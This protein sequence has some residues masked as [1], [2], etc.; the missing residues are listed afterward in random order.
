MLH[1]ALL[2]CLLCAALAQLGACARGA[3]TTAPGDGSVDTNTTE[4][5]WRPHIGQ[6]RGPG[7]KP[8]DAAVHTP[9]EGGAG[10]KKDKGPGPAAVDKDGDGHCSKGT[11]DP[12]GK[13]KSFNDCDDKDASRH[14]GAL[15]TCK[16]MGVDNDCDGDAKE[17]DLNKDGK[18]DLGMACQTSKPGVCSAGQKRC[19]KGKLVCQSNI[20]PGQKKETCNGQDDDCDGTAD[21]GNLCG[22]G[23]SCQGKKGCRCATSPACVG[24]EQCCG[25]SCQ[26]IQKDPSHCGGCGVAC[27]AGES[28][29]GGAC[30][31]G[32]TVGKVGGGKACTGGTCSGGACLACNPGSNL[33][34][35][36]AASSSGGG[37]GV[38]GP[39]AMRNNL[40]QAQCDFHWVSA[41]SA[42]GGKWV[43][44]SWSSPVL[45][46]RVWFD[47]S[48]LSGSC[49]LSSG[50]TLYGGKVQY[51][52][53]GG[54]KS[55]AVVSGKT[56]D[57]S[58]SF[59]QVST[60]KLR[61]HDLHAPNTIGQ[62]SNPII[63]EWRVYCK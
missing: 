46:G 40:L 2:L 43:Q 26:D 37:F 50:R 14:P 18:S 54:W 36:A 61:F 51:W 35:A 27:G 45:V 41:G 56:S 1:R 58:V 12:K 13:C 19:A 39:D 31:C 21:N 57:W 23:N 52:S 32:A 4:G 15:E 3:S 44:Y 17:V 63:Y 48:P 42:P 11:K 33:A 62:K 25:G 60:T 28:C 34:T 9:A 8:G 49:S 29:S 7:P 24:D 10:P 6:D 30:R 38:R 16:N 47:T 20:S 22:K 53:A 59:K 5:D 55:L